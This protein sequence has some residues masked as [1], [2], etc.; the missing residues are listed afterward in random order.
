MIHHANLL[1]RSFEREE[2]LIDVAIKVQMDMAG[3]DV[4]QEDIKNDFII[5][6]KD[7]LGLRALRG[8]KTYK[9]VSIS[10][11]LIVKQKKE[12]QDLYRWIRKGRHQA[13]QDQYEDKGSCR[14]ETLLETLP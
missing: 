14:G 8:S 6:N 13:T 5:E 7:L 2:D 12:K 3:V 9:D 11:E 1:K 4:I 10:E